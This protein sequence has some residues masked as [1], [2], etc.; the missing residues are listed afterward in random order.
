MT[1]SEVFNVGDKV[2]H[3]LSGQKMTILR[4]SETVAY[5]KGPKYKS[6]ALDKGWHDRYVCLIENLISPTRKAQLKLFTP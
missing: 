4:M 2:T 1:K 5:L 6:E 3:K